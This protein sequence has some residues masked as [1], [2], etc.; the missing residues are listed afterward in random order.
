MNLLPEQIHGTVGP[1]LEAKETELFSDSQSYSHLQQR[2]I[3]WKN[4]LF[5][6]ELTLE[7]QGLLIRHKPDPKMRHVG[8]PL[9]F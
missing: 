8:P 5:E 4:S 9:S 6:S 2:E 7:M 3:K 1:E